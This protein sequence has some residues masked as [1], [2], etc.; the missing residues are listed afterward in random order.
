MIRVGGR[1]TAYI[2]LYVVV[3]YYVLLPSVRKKCSYYLNRRFPQAGAWDR[4]WNSYRMTLDLGKVLVDRALVGILGP[5]QIQ[6]ELQGKEELLDVLAEN[7]GVILVNAHVGCWQV[8][9]SA[10]GF[11][12]TPVNLLMQREDGDIDRHYFE[13]AGIECPYRI[14]DPR[15]DLGGVLKMV[16]VLK[17]GEVLSVMGDRMLGEDRNG[18]DVEFFGDPVTVPFSAYKLASAT[19]APIVVLFSYK[20]GPDKYELQLYKTIRVPSGLGRGSSVFKPYAREFAQTLEVFCA[21][22]PFQFFNFF[23]MWQNQ[24]SDKQSKE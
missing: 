4:F 3:F 20:T 24:P 18:V 13:H 19:G 9:M 6:V 8:A 11:M 5:E 7:K 16:E 14:I 17:R 10:L 23:D 22:H 15:G 2:P 12:E 1:R 21:E